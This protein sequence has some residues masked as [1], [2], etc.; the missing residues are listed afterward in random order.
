MQLLTIEETAAILKVAPKTIRNWRV[1]GRLKIPVV[2]FNG[3]VRFNQKDV[4]AY[5][6]SR[7]KKQRA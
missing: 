7:T 6:E 3:C 1:E 4:E 5:I 2:L